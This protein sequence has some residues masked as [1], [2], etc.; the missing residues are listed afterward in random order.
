MGL[1]ISMIVLRNKDTRTEYRF[2][3]LFVAAK[4]A[5]NMSRTNQNGWIMVEE[6]LGIEYPSS[7][8]RHLASLCITPEKE[9]GVDSRDIFY[10]KEEITEQEF[11]SC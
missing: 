6:E 10:T 9:K 8:W 7:E 4:N 11:D 5:V 1:L 3:S 2:T